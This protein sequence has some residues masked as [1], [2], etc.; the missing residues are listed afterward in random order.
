MQKVISKDGTEIAF[1]KLGTGSPVI[2]V[3]GA[4]LFRRFAQMV[5]LSERLSSNFTVI[6][7]DRRGRG[8]SGD[9]LPYSVQREVEDLEALIQFAGGSSAVFGIS[10]GAALAIEAATSGLNITKLALYEPPFVAEDT[11]EIRNDPNKYLNEVQKLIAENKR[12]DA[13]KAFLRIVGVPSFIR[14][15]LPLMPGWKNGL[16][17][18]HTLPYDFMILKGMAVPMKALATL[19]IPTLVMN[20]GA[21]APRLMKAAEATSRAISNSTYQVL[22]KQRHDVAPS[23]LADAITQFFKTRSE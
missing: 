18:A 5:E 19:K 15:I 23:V 7:Y 21:T 3:G 17:V 2:L 16:T 9:T 11:E 20:G 14:L 6:N 4:M 22:P 10:S 1:D 8:D 12:S 13:V